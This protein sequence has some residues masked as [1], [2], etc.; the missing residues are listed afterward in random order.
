MGEP[1]ETKLLT[2]KRGALKEEGPLE[3]GRLVL[4]I[5][6]MRI[7]WLFQ[8][9][10]D[11]QSESFPIPI[12]GPFPESLVPFFGIIE[13]WFS[14][15]ALPELTRI[16]L[17]VVLVEPVEDKKLGYQRI[18][19]YL[20]TIKL[21][22]EK[23]SDFS[24]QIN[25]PRPS[26]SGIKDLSVKRISRWSVSLHRAAAIS[27]GPDSAEAATLGQTYFTTRLEVDINTAPDFKGFLPAEHLSKILRELVSLAEEIASKG[28]IP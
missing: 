8:S 9:I 27:V 24:Y 26:T 22:T 12:I 15:E 25:R 17:G 28:D 16:A 3:K 5:R 21:D 10:Y 6:P 19:K 20:P 18:S 7:D 2:P 23:S 13:R 4:N 14:L 11:D 1:P